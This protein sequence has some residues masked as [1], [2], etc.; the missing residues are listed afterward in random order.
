MKENLSTSHS[1]I[2][3]G[4]QVQSK[5]TKEELNKRPE[6]LTDNYNR[7]DGKRKRSKK[8]E[9]TPVRPRKRNIIADII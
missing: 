1:S 2:Y 5:Y 8:G 9:S 4:E 6:K 7:Y 3:L